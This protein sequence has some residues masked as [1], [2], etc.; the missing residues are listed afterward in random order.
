MKN[1]LYKRYG[2]YPKKKEKPTHRKGEGNLFRR[3]H[4]WLRWKIDQI[5]GAAFY[6]PC[7]QP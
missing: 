6:R 2:P 7:L 3:G 1:E 5:G 4:Q